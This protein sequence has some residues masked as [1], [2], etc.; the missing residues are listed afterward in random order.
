MQAGSWNL[1]ARTLRLLPGPTS[2]TQENTA[3]L[4][5]MQK[6]EQENRETLHTGTLDKICTNVLLPSLQL[7][8]LNKETLSAKLF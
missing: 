5:G 3:W 4:K 8:G 6:D 2:T 7:T 1:A